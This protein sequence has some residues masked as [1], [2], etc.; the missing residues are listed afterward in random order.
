MSDSIVAEVYPAEDLT[1]L[2]ASQSVAESSGTEYVPSS[3]GLT[4]SSNKSQ[5]SLVTMNHPY[6]KHI[7]LTDCLSGQWL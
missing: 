5:V 6:W 4:E 2:S 3:G 1:D 7:H